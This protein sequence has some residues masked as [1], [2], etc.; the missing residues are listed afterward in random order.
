MRNP[1][2]QSLLELL[3]REHV[4]LK[5]GHLARLA[6][7]VDEKLEL[8][9]A[10]RTAQPTYEDLEILR[11]KAACNV[12]LLAAAIRGVKAARDRIASVSEVRDLLSVY[13]PKGEIQRVAIGPGGLEQKA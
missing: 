2:V 8:E 4:I 1:T 7:L 12:D 13:G 9:T 6:E 11:A 5:A 10:L 3:D